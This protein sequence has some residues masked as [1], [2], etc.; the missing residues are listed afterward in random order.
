MLLSTSPLFFA[1]DVVV[2]Y[3]DAQR[4]AIAHIDGD[5]SA[6]QL[7][8]SD[9]DRHTKRDADAHAMC[10]GLRHGV[11][12]DHCDVRCMSFRASLE[13]WNRLSQCNYAV[14]RFHFGQQLSVQLKSVDGDSE[15]FSITCHLSECDRA[16]N[17]ND[18]HLCVRLCFSANGRLSDAERVRFDNDD[19]KWLVVAGFLRIRDS[20]EL[21][22]A[23][24]VNDAYDDI[25]YI[26]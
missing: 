2:G 18:V 5:T 14:D 9:R 23:D 24:A 15:R 3:Y 21:R 6:E 10:N 20:H 8:N 1:D 22:Y 12:D 16:A 26:T 19:W 7:S 11:G 25:D 13:K 17:G 4:Y